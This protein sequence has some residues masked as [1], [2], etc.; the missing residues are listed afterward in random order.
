M[1]ARGARSAAPD[2]HAEVD[3]SHAVSHSIVPESTLRT[4]EVEA[5]ARDGF[6]IKRGLFARDE[7]RLLDEAFVG[8]RAMHRR[9]YAVA[10][11][12]GAST[13]IALWNDPGDDLFGAFA[14]CARMVRGAEAL[15]GGEVYHY[16][17]KITMKPPG[18]GGT[19]NWHQDYGYW[20]KNGCLYPDMLTVAVAMNA[21]N[22][23]NG[24]LEV[25]R[26]SH[27]LGRI[28][29]GQVGSQT[30]ADP[31]RVRA[32]L[33]RSERVAFEA[34]PGD[35]MFFHCNTLHT[36][37]PNRSQRPRDLFLIAYNAA[38]ND[39]CLPHHHPGYTKLDVLPDDAIRARAGV[40]AGESRVF[41]DPA[42]DKSI[43]GFRR[44]G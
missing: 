19:W 22:R 13:E 30:G 40:W 4:S 24:C 29:H 43:Y 3:M 28:E 21:A 32:V 25:I 7:M 12:A 16:H 35:V 1:A 42:E 37:A 5:F 11:D 18:G 20:Y 36:S 15:L 10:D 41:L 2:F 38:A 31:E 14:R 6:L 39:P 8:D 34:E 17:S 33:E 27:R 44:L 26:G 23:E 9:A